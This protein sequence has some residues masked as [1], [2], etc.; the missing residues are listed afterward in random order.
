MYAVSLLA[1]VVC[2]L[3]NHEQYVAQSSAHEV[4]HDKSAR[5]SQILAASKQSRGED[6]LSALV[7][8]TSQRNARER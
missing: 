4:I 7:R 5:I 8:H 6:R 3:V 2:R 1:L